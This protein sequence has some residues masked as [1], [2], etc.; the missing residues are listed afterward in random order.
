MQTPPSCQ[1][2]SVRWSF[3]L[4]LDGKA[5]V[6]MQRGKWRVTG[7]VWGGGKEGERWACVLSFCII[8]GPDT[9]HSSVQTHAILAI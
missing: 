9:L 8:K 6:T 4:N 7:V 5:N 2:R 3:D 1:S